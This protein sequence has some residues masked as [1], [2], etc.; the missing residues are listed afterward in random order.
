MFFDCCGSMAPGAQMIGA[1]PSVC[2]A[3]GKRVWPRSGHTCPRACA[4]DA[5]AP[6]MKPPL[7]PFFEYLPHG[8]IARGE[9]GVRGKGGLAGVHRGAAHTLGGADMTEAERSRRTDAGAAA[10][11]TG[12]AANVRSGVAPEPGRG[13]GAARMK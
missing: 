9:G 6:H 2:A 1:V 10:E 11:P 8:G 7:P 12:A 3:P 5:T 4:G 13:R